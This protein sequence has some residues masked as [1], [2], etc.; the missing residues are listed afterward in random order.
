MFGANRVGKHHSD[1]SLSTD[2]T[3]G[4]ADCDCCP[5][6]DGGGD[7]AHILLLILL[8]VAV[9]MAII[10]FFVGLIITVVVCQRVVQTHVYLLQK[11]QL[12]H[13][14]QVMDLSGYDLSRPEP[15]APPASM[16]VE[17]QEMTPLA[18]PLPEKDAS[19]LRSLGLM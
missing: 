15:S 4:G 18:P 1:S 2:H 17:L 11:R 7:A 5:N 12:A 19:Y 8:V 3:S 14:F 16:D 9:V 6:N 13:E 10:G